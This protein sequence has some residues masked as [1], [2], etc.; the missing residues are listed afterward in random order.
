MCQLIKKIPRYGW[1]II[2]FMS[3][4]I[5]IQH[6]YMAHHCQE[7]EATTAPCVMKTI[8]DEFVVSECKLVDIDK[9]NNTYYYYSVRPGCNMTEYTFVTDNY[10]KA[11]YIYSCYFNITYCRLIMTDDSI[12]VTHQ[13][14][15]TAESVPVTEK[16]FAYK[17][18]YNS[19]LAQKRY[20]IA[21]CYTTWLISGIAMPL[22]GTYVVTLTTLII[23]KTMDLHCT[24]EE[25]SEEESEEEDIEMNSTFSSSDDGDA[26]NKEICLIC[27]QRLTYKSSVLLLCCKSV[28]HNSCYIKYYSETGFNCFN[29]WCP[30]RLKT[31]RRSY[32]IELDPCI[33][34]LHSMNDSST[35]L[36]TG[37]CNNMV[38]Q[39]CHC[40]SYKMTKCCQICKN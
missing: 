16:Y 32:I 4:A 18:E 6:I 40:L 30:N 26:N 25:E 12:P 36:W 29:Q 13:Y 17:D 8:P 22:I 23:V 28:I 19:C 7:I 21:A 20:E 33:Y 27:L 38:H 2:I 37:C 34:C 10:L 39:A 3:I 35:L 5:T 24:H 14:I 9:E 31:F 11:Y 15:F 1:F